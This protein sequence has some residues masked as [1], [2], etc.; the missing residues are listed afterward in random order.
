MTDAVGIAD[1]V[2]VGRTVEVGGTVVA[3]ATGVCDATEVAVGGRICSAIGLPSMP[4]AIVIASRTNETTSHCWPA[5]ILARL[6]R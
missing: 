3:D 5:T 6:V 4:A 2:D 1:A